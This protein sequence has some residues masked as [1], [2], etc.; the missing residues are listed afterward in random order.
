MFDALQHPVFASLRLPNNG[1]VKNSSYYRQEA[2]NTNENA[3]RFMHYY[4]GGAGQS[5]NTLP[6]L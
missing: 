4:R 5:E 6:I 3:V 2:P 1:T